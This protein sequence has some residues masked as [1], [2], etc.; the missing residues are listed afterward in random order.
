MKKSLETKSFAVVVLES[1]PRLGRPLLVTHRVLSDCRSGNRNTEF[2]QFSV[3][4]GSAPEPVGR[5]QF[6]D[7]STNL[8][9]HQPGAL[10]QDHSSR[11]SRKPL[12]CQAI[13]ASGLTM[14]RQSL[15][16]RINQSIRVS[17]RAY[18]KFAHAKIAFTGLIIGSEG[19]FQPSFTR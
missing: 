5:A 1:A 11:P 3:D 19:S 7:Q 17:R 9:R 4:A 8:T 6:P 13:T 15:Q 14:S 10:C 16:R 18:P 2:P 12:R